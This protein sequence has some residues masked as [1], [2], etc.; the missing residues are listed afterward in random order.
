MGDLGVQA[1]R[2]S[3]WPSRAGMCRRVT[4][5]EVKVVAHSKERGERLGLRWHLIQLQAEDLPRNARLLSL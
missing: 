5:P 3:H 1:G 4:A 2:F